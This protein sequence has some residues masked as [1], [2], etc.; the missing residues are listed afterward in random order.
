MTAK[1]RKILLIVLAAILLIGAAGAWIGYGLYKKVMLPNVAP[2]VETGIFIHAGDDL[3]DILAQ[4]DQKNILV[5]ND[6][7]AWWAKRLDELH[8]T[9][10]DIVERDGHQVLDVEDGEGQRLTLM[11]DGGWGEAHPW[12]KSPVPAEYVPAPDT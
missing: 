2:D 4:F 12:E 11:D 10:G 1:T 7:F 5:D 3:T 9:H 6:A 8:I